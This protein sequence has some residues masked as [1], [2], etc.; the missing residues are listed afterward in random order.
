MP[1]AGTIELL[2]LPGMVATEIYLINYRDLV[3]RLANYSELLCTHD[4]L[5]NISFI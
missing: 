2:F 5:E 1:V 4:R 3:L